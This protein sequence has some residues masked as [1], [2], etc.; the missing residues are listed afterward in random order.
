[1]NDKKNPCHRCK[2]RKGVHKFNQTAPAL[3][4]WTVVELIY[5][6]KVWYC[7]PCL[8]YLKQKAAVHADDR[9]LQEANEL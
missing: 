3:P 4:P 9:R 6:P 2:E 1:M 7:D 5:L 8:Q